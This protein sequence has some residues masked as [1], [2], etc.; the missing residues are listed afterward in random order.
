M[1]HDIRSDSVTRS[2][3]IADAPERVFDALTQEFGTWFQVNLDGPF[4]EG[5]SVSGEMTMPGAAGLPF[6]ARTIALERPVRFVFDWPQWD[7]EANRSLEDSA[8]WTRVAFE[9][10]PVAE[11][12]R[13]TVTESGFGAY[14]SDLG[15]RLLRENTAGWDLQLRNLVTHVTA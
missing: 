8:P 9:L 7:F 6:K 10:A 12:T 13:V 15:Q 14:P 2:I 11:G 4:R 3:V 1:T 5:G